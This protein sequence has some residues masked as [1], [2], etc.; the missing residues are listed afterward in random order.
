MSV[1]SQISVW[2]IKLKCEKK[3]Q[4][5][6]EI[7]NTLKLLKKYEGSLSVIIISKNKNKVEELT[8]PKGL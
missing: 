8:Q 2:K 5:F 1:L 3:M 6:M 7:S 4:I